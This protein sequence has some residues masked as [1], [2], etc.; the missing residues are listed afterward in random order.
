MMDVNTAKVEEMIFENRRVNITDL[1]T[2]L[3]SLAPQ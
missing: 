2:A 3:E 1:S